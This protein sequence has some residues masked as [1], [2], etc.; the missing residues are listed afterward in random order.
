M[1]SRV[2]NQGSEDGRHSISIGSI[3]VRCSLS[4]KHDQIFEVTS[5]RVSWM[6]MRMTNSMMSAQDSS[7]TGIDTFAP[8]L[9]RQTLLW[10]WTRK[11]IC[12]NNLHSSVFFIY[13]KYV[14]LCKIILASYHHLTVWY[15]CVDVSSKN[16]SKI[17]REFF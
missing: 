6:T 8:T 16:I 13:M 12:K 9:L 14:H 2:R 17:L 11:E 1:S 3:A 4:K 7:V 15:Y 10:I 5:L